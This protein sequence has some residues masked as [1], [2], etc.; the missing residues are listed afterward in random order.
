MPKF[1]K[2]SAI[3][4][5]DGGIETYNLSLFGLALP[6]IKT[7]RTAETKYAPILGLLGASVELIVKACLVQA[8]GDSAMYKNNDISSG[9]YKFGSDVFKE[10]RVG[11]RDSN[12]EFAFVLKSEKSEGQKQELLS[13][14][15]KFELLLQLRAQ[16]LHAG[17][18]CSRDVLIALVN[19]VYS[20]ILILSSGKKMGAYLRNIPTPE[21]PIRDREAILEDLSRRLTN[22]KDIN[23]KADCLRSMY[24]VL[25]YIPEVQPDWLTVFD[26]FQVALPQEQDLSYLIRTL[27]EARSIYLLKTR[28][29]KEG[30]P[31]RIDNSNSEALPIAV[32]NLKRELNSIPDKF[33]N[34]VLTANT[35]LEENRLDLPIDD[36]IIDLYSIGIKSS[37]ILISPNSMLT[38]Q[39]V[40]AFVAAAIQT[41]G[42]PRPYWFMIKLCNELPKLKSVLLRIKEIGNAFYRKRIDIVIE[43]I[44]AL[45]ENREIRFDKKDSLY[46]E[47]INY[48]KDSIKASQTN[49]FTP[50]NIK[51][52]PLSINVSKDLSRY[53]NGTSSP[54]IALTN[55]LAN[56][57]LPENDKKVARQLMSLCNRYKDRNG[58]IAV[59]RTTPLE[60]YKSVA[61]KMIYYTDFITNGPPISGIDKSI[62]S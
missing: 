41:Q 9:V 50:A 46:I 40:W 17:Q 27:T 54:G 37:G 39:Q 32:Q 20:F 35:R 62:F 49:Q 36:F 4:L 23:L 31:V 53:L 60:G 33:N 59:L 14:I 19:D 42:T 24:L 44:D 15:A 57:A 34:D 51:K 28:G 25:P 61:R 1:M 52:Y 11:L 6:A 7:R 5:L 26:K 38:A 43:G 16:G 10:F 29:G 48:F 2:N 8:K 3:K 22:T 13:M 55:I 30:I 47:L 58:L 45:I 56:S 18:G 12:P 21:L